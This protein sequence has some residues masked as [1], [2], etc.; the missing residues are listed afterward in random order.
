MSQEPDNHEQEPLP[1]IK[2][3]NVLDSIFS[4][5]GPMPT[6]RFSLRAVALVLDC[7]LMTAVASIIIWKIALPQSHPAAFGELMQWSQEVVTWV[8][9][10]EP[11]T[12]LPEPSQELARA[13]AV[14]NELQLLLFWIYFAVGEAFFKGSSLG[15]RICRIR[16]VST[17]NLGPPQFLAGIIRGGL[18]TVTLFWL[19]PLAFGATFIALFFNKRRQLGHDLCARTTVVD[20]KYVN[21][22]PKS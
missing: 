12:P 18:K 13:L 2:P 22:Q 1:P 4:E 8:E 9:K 3:D 5:G 15:K 10:Q 19:F 6:A 14:A 21:L 7:I 11:D 20:E 17:V 16:S